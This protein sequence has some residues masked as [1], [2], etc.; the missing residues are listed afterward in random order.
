[1]IRTQ[2]ITTDNLFRLTVML[3][4]SDEGLSEEQYMTLQMYVND[5][6]GEWKEV[7]NLWKRVDATDGR[8]YLKEAA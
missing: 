5:E 1:M 3:L 2:D 8:F 7:Q 4:D 6:I